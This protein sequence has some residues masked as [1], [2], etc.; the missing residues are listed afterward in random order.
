[1]II[2]VLLI[3]VLLTAQLLPVALAEHGLI[4]L[5][6]IEVVLVPM[7][8]ALVLLL[9]AQVRVV[10]QLQQENTVGLAHRLE[11]VALLHILV[12][13]LEAHQALHLEVTAALLTQGLQ[14]LVVQELVGL[15]VVLVA[16]VLLRVVLGEAD[17]KLYNNLLLFLMKIF[18]S[19]LMIG[20]LCTPLTLLSQNE[21]DAL[22]FSQTQP[23][24]TA[25]SSGVGGAVGAVGS[26]MSS[27]AVNPASLA[28]YRKS[29]FNFTLGGGQAI[30]NS[31]YLGSEISDQ[32]YLFNLSNLS[33]VS[34]ELM[35]D[36]G[37][38]PDN[39]LV[40]YSLAFQLNR[41][42]NFHNKTLYKGRNTKSSFLDMIWENAIG[43]Y[44][45]ELF[46]REY[47]AY[48]TFLLNN[49]PVGS[50][51]W[52]I[53]LKNEER[54]LEQTG[55]IES[56]GGVYNFN[57]GGAFNYG[58]K[59]LLGASI[60]YNVLRFNEVNSYRE[61]NNAYLDGFESMRFVTDL[62]TRGQG[63][64]LNFGAL[65]RFSDMFR[66][67]FSFV[68]PVYFNMT[69]KYKYQMS[70]TFNPNSTNLPPDLQELNHTI[71]LPEPQQSIFGG[72][73]DRY[74]S[75]YTLR[76]PART[77]L[78]AAYLNPEFGLVS[79]DV[80]RVDY[81]RMNMTSKAFTDDYTD[82]NFAIKEDFRRVT[83]VRVGFEFLQD[84]FRWRGGMGFYQTPYAE[85]FEPFSS[86]TTEFLL[87]GGFG[88]R[89]PKYAIDLGLMQLR[90][91]DVVYPYITDDPAYPSSRVDR[92]LRHIMFTTSISFL[93]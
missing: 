5:L 42:T 24:G 83:N 91:S 41:N 92:H 3:E 37:K 16:V 28:L 57:V 71:V 18:L 75:D 61:F 27:Y 35:Y 19:F 87:S 46:D 50:D 81:R 38:E 80:E 7:T 60:R 63:W 30:A 88:I 69:D 89:K 82:V 29:E 6:P 65:Y 21:L 17:V 78:S 43:F 10:Q 73:I 70:S 86:V 85:N 58:N 64:G 49:D 23:L 74:E 90:N 20:V 40:S 84:D 14:A 36:R 39:D 54:D 11:A 51:D 59:L 76:T 72:V 15:V 25:F 55:E 62:Q 9:A 52:Y 66:A 31:T 44:E 12:V 4:Q 32:R 8:E 68:S 26:D 45:E 22:R 77:T 34:T 53:T 48:E 47:M 1:M 2:V 13:H 56:S 79:I 93:F 67:G 33:Y